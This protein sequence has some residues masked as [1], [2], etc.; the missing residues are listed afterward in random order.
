ML[1]LLKPKAPVEIREKVWTERRMRWLTHRLG[2]DRLKAATM[3]LPTREFFPD[4][5]AGEPEDVAD[6]FSHV[7][8]FMDTS[9]DRFELSVKGCCQDG[10][11]CDPKPGDKPVVQVGTEDVAD[12]ERLIATLSRAVAR[13]AL[14]GIEV[15]REQADDFDSLTDLTAVFLGMGVFQANTAVKS[16]AYSQGGW[17][18]WSIR[19]AG[20][21]QARVPGYAMALM[22]WVRGESNP[23]WASMLGTDAAS[24]FHKGYK[25][26]TR[27]NDCLFRPDNADLPDESRSSASLADDLTRGTETQKLAAMWALM[28]NPSNASS[29]IDPLAQCVKHRNPGIAAEAAR[30]VATLGSSAQSALPAILEQLSAQ[31]SE[32]RTY[33]AIAVGAIKPQ[34]DACPDGLQV[35][36]EL[37]PLLQDRNPQV[38]DAALGTL[39]LYGKEAE[40]AL[41]AVVPRIIHYARDCDFALLESAVG[42]IAKVVEDPHEFFNQYLENAD[43]E[44]RDRILAEL[45]TDTDGGS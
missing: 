15:T 37:I 32:V 26:V 29:T 7:C 17:E 1:G 10:A 42:R 27:T 11:C 45:E 21:L 44:I 24:A 9:A 12:Q 13:E 5:Y 39:S 4:Q 19:G 43:P 33:C 16:T 25:Y 22:A 8:E 38:V 31:E 41:A 40:P 14:T 28:Q 2:I 3:V 34:L 35:R 18:Y 6:V 36:E 30:T 20:H 23:A